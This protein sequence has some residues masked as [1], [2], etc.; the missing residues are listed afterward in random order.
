MA[1]TPKGEV[2]PLLAMGDITLDAFVNDYVNPHNKMRKRSH[3]RDVQLYARVG[4]KF[5]KLKL[6]EISR[7]EVQVFHNDLVKVERL[8]PATADHHVVYMRR[9]LNLAVQ[10]E[11]LEKNTL[12]NIPLL[13][14]DNKVERYLSDEEVEKLVDVLTKDLAF[15]ASYI[16]MFLLSTGA[17]LNEAMQAKWDQVDLDT[18]VWRIPATNSKSKKTRSVPLKSKKTRSVPLNESAIWVLKQLWTRDVHPFL[19]VNEATQKPFVTITRAWYRLRAKAG[20]ETLRIHDL[21]H[22]FASFLVNGGR[23]LYEVQQILGHSD[24]KVTMRYAHLSTKALQEAAN[25]A[26]VIVKKPELQAA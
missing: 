10:W 9:L 12:T 20:I 26:S 4:A 17:R 3:G 7:R 21:R 11:L 24:P 16:L 14:V 22:S 5:G 13:K 15:G 1:T 23:S 8:A 6:S 18:G 2:A 19:F 25:V